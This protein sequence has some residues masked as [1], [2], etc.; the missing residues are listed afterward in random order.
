VRALQRTIGNRAM[1]R[2]LQRQPATDTGAG[3]T[4]QFTDDAK[5]LL[6]DP[7][8]PDGESDRLISLS[9]PEFVANYIDNNIVNGTVWVNQDTGEYG[10][11]TVE[12]SGGRKHKF[13][14]DEMPMPRKGPIVRRPGATT[15]LRLR[16]DYFQIGPGGLIFPMYDGSV[17]YDEWLTPNL[18]SMRGQTHEKAD[19]LR[20]LRLLL[21][22]AGA[23]ASIVAMYGLTMKQGKTPTHKPVK[24]IGQSKTPVLARPPT[25]RTNPQ[26]MGQTGVK[27]RRGGKVGFFGP[28]PPKKALKPGQKRPRTDPRNPGVKSDTTPGRVQSRINI[29]PG[30]R[31]HGSHKLVEGSG[32]WYAWSKHGGHGPKN[33]SQFI[34]P[35]ATI[36]NLLKT[37]KVIKTPARPLDNG[38]F[39]REVDF[40]A[41]TVGKMPENEGATPTSVMTVITDKWGNLVNTFPGTLAGNATL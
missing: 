33:K 30:I 12:Y 10:D 37:E 17:V 38:N 21:W 19:E 32:F 11:M 41:V 34:H 25:K 23:F 29:R 20:R 22:T 18:I 5:V 39:V 16:F 13:D 9:D 26:L 40:D 36:H 4:G 35:P 6:V 14:L 28:P 3:T 27:R 15:A 31:K 1:G 24:Q 2:L 7:S 8:D